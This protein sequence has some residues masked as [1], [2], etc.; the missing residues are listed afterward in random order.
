MKF[1][2]VCSAN[3]LRSP[4]AEAAFSTIQGIEALSAGTNHDAETPISADLIEWADIVFAM[5]KTHREKLRKKFGPLLR[6]KRIVVLGI[7]DEYSY[8]DP[9]LLQVLRK[10]MRP[11]L[12]GTGDEN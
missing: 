12:S 3:R 2:F 8:M 1:L 9:N 10:K 5:E 4:T 11:Y 6:A 7:P